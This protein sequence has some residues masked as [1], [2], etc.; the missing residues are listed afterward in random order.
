MVWQVILSA[1][2]GSFLQSLLRRSHAQPCALLVLGNIQDCGAV[3]FGPL[4]TYL[5]YSRTFQ[6]AWLGIRLCSHVVFVTAQSPVCQLF[7]PGKSQLCLWKQWSWDSC[8]Y[9][10]GLCLFSATTPKV[11]HWKAAVNDPGW[12]EGSQKRCCADCISGRPDI[13]V[14]NSHQPS[15][16]WPGFKDNGSYSPATSTGK[17]R[18]TLAVLVPETIFWVSPGA[19]CLPRVFSLW[20]CSCSN[21]RVATHIIQ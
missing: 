12:R 9:D 16:T 18:S 19:R 4:G 3:L 5:W 14:S 10:C 20:D 7:S 11:E 1:L 13:L 8:I 15:S 21:S 17:G 2:P 6:V